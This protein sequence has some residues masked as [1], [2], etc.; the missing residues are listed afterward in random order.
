LFVGK[1]WLAVLCPFNNQS[2]DLGAGWWSIDTRL[3]MWGICQ[4]T[5]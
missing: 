5:M 4:K 1:C 2:V 3:V